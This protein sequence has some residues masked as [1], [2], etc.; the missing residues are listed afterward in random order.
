MVHDLAFING[1]LTFI[2]V[3]PTALQ[4]CKEKAKQ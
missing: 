4:F 2:G 3:M 1:L